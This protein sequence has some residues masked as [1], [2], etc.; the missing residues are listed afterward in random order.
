MELYVNY[1]LFPLLTEPGNY[2]CML[3][4][5]LN[6]SDYQFVLVK[7]F[8]KG[9]AFDIERNRL[10]NL[11]L[12]FYNKM[13]TFFCDY[14]AN[15]RISSRIDEMVLLSAKQYYEVSKSKRKTIKYFPMSEF[16]NNKTSRL[17]GIFLK[18]WFVNQKPKDKICNLNYMFKELMQKE[19]NFIES[20]FGVSE[21]TRANFALYNNINRVDGLR[22][23]RKTDNINKY[24][25]K[26]HVEATFALLDRKQIDMVY[27]ANVKFLCDQYLLLKKYDLMINALKQRAYRISNKGRLDDIITDSKKSIKFTDS[28]VK[29]WH[30]SSIAKKRITLIK[31]YIDS[32]VNTVRSH[33]AQKHVIQYQGGKIDELLK[34][35]MNLLQKKNNAVNNQDR[36][37]WLGIPLGKIA[38]DK[39][40]DRLSQLIGSH[41]NSN[42]NNTYGQ[43][44]RNYVRDFNQFDKE[45]G[46]NQGLE[47]YS[48]YDALIFRD[49]ND[50]KEYKKLP[51]ISI[52]KTNIDT[53]SN[54]CFMEV[55]FIYILLAKKVDEY[56]NQK[57]GQSR[58]V[59]VCYPPLEIEYDTKDDWNVLVESSKERVLEQ[60]FKLSPGQLLLVPVCEKDV[61]FSLLA[62]RQ[63]D[64]DRLVAFYFDSYNTK[65]YPCLASFLHFDI[66]ER[67]QHFENRSREF[68]YQIFTGNYQVN[69]DCAFHVINAAYYIIDSMHFKNKF[70][71]KHFNQFLS[72]NEYII[73]DHSDDKFECNNKTSF[74]M[75]CHYIKIA[76][77]IDTSSLLEIPNYDL[78]DNQM[79][80]TE[81][82]DET[83]TDL[84]EESKEK[85]ARSSDMAKFWS[86][87]EDSIFKFSKRAIKHYQHVKNPAQV[88][89]HN[90][91][92]CSSV[93][94]R[95]WIIYESAIKKIVGYSVDMHNQE[96]SFANQ[97]LMIEKKQYLESSLGNRFYGVKSKNNS[98]LP[99]MSKSKW[100]FSCDSMTYR[101]AQHRYNGL[102]NYTTNKA[103]KV[104]YLFIKQRLAIYRSHS[105]NKKMSRLKIVPPSVKSQKNSLHTAL[106]LILDK[107]N[108]VLWPQD[109]HQ[110]F[111]DCM[112][113]IFKMDEF[114]AKSMSDYT[115]KS[116]PT[117]NDVSVQLESMVQEL[118]N[119]V[120]SFRNSL[121]SKFKGF[122]MESIDSLSKSVDEQISN[123]KD[124]VMSEF[125]KI[126]GTLLVGPVLGIVANKAY[127]TA[128]NIKKEIDNDIEEL[129]E[130][131]DN[132]LGELKGE[133]CQFWLA[134]E[135]LSFEVHLKALLYTLKTTEKVGRTQIWDTHSTKCNSCKEKFGMLQR[136]RVHHCRVCG[137]KVCGDCSGKARSMDKF[138]LVMEKGHTANKSN[139]SFRMCLN[140][141]RL[142]VV[143]FNWVSKPK[144]KSVRM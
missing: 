125:V 52:K 56:C 136:K 64:Q 137:S 9:C 21:F 107:D 44:S 1:V 131:V 33:L 116:L 135:L 57:L 22:V 113:S 40:G 110:R 130:K 58:N 93:F 26:Y 95:F 92:V 90:L 133:T 15:N 140:C 74:D 144:N 96:G 139:E 72:T 37:G 35:H 78:A 84:V 48:N 115:V 19:V 134:I 55:D 24:S 119:E 68:S 13:N 77:T 31:E 43:L 106:K 80:F 11:S 114:I 122:M 2:A 86:K 79:T 36:K 47:K 138:E 62:F 7:N 121:T 29:Y 6:K 83:L 124:S 104:S 60:I 88:A 75:R 142:R 99:F 97:A 69:N 129:K 123:I 117:K 20:L 46:Q 8:L 70:I 27:H 50:T 120:A 71:R 85:K 25:A 127:S 42:E 4:A 109:I 39:K 73:R 17:K 45:K 100:S 82:K 105:S 59:H 3:Q 81:S 30:K 12:S 54:A 118:L 141:A 87:Y 53:D 126:G 67:Y 128:T 16:N 91:F 66:R 28:G 23:T 102:A 18:K 51:E 5:C 41:E 65:P 112:N 143:T 10:M 94:W 61:H 63:M 98:T 103:D 111:I 76:R 108:H 34:S 14:Q 101:V 89:I 38:S 132:K 49:I 32:S